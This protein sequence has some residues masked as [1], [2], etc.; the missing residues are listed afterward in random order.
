[1]L[2]TIKVE[3]DPQGRVHPLQ[4]LPPR[5]ERLALLTLEVPLSPGGN[6]KP[7]SAAALLEFL[8][9]YPLIEAERRSPQEMEAQIQAERNVWD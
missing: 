9:F 8:R 4:P 6:H 1:M 7:G 2:K 3:I 5:C